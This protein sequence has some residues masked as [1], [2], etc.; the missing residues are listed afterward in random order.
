VS[1][2]SCAVDRCM[3]IMESFSFLNR[4]FF[5]H[6]NLLT[7]R[8]VIHLHSA[9]SSSPS[10]CVGILGMQPVLSRNYKQSTNRDSYCVSIVLSSRSFLFRFE[11]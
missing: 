7:L 5:I 10:I 1:S 2:P 9:L 3:Y 8:F 4:I 6:V 11:N